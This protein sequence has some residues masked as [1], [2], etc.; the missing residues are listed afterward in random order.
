MAEWLKVFP[1]SADKIFVSQV[2]SDSPTGFGLVEKSVSEMK[3]L[4]GLPSFHVTK[5]VQSST[6]DPRS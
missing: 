2:D 5:W 6:G 1:S 3:T 4:L